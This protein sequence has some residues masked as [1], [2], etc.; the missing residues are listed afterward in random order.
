MTFDSP[1]VETA[2][3]A[4]EEPADVSASGLAH[5]VF[6]PDRAA[7]RFFV[8][9][10]AAERSPL[11][12]L[13]AA[14]TEELP[15]ERLQLCSVQGFAIPLASALPYLAGLSSSEVSFLSPSLA[16]WSLSAKL[17]LDLVARE[18]VVPR[19]VT[20]GKSTE[21]R[22]CV[23]LSLR[24]DL[25]RFAALAKAFPLAAHALPLTK[26]SGRNGRKRSNSALRVW[27]ADALLKSFLDI[28]AD[29]LAREARPAA[30]SAL[31]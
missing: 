24:D 31:K 29:T 8:W 18:R 3:A 10:S 30:G 1:N 17:A 14:A 9:G 2:D 4:P 23:A 13:G 22:S 7:P 21:A 6:V 12:H 5:L 26:T 25:D 28:V 20:Q 27:S 19:I 11:R 15:D 16:V